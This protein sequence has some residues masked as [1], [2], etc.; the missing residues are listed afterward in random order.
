MTKAELVDMIRAKAGLSTKAQT[1][2]AMDS[3]ITALKETL[4]AGESIGF[5]GFG[6]FKVV[7]RA[8]RKGRNPRTGKDITIPAGKAVK[9]IP[10]KLLK[11]AIK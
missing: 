9:F 1:E 8:E 11:E 2:Q 4:A 7:L 6:G 5:T 10:G 3:I